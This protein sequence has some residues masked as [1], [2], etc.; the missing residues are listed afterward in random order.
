MK[1]KQGLLRRAVAFC[2]VQGNQEG[3]RDHEK[4]M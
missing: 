1:E 3:R 4:G 2:I